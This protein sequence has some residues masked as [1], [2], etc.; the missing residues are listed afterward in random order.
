MAVSAEYL[1][2]KFSLQKHPE[3]GYYGEVYRSDESIQREH[4]PGR[5]HSHRNF[6]TSIYFLLESNDFSAFHRVNSDELWHFYAGTSLTL[7]IINDHGDLEKIILGNKSEN[8]ESYYAVINRGNW[9]A[10]KT[11]QSN[12]FTLVGCTVSPGFDFEDFEL[13]NRNELIK[14]FPQHKELITRFTTNSSAS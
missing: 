4:L 6:S 1:I 10:A 8:D 2:N 3:G 13:A 11:N 9:F 5:Y 14:Q 7:Y 12:S